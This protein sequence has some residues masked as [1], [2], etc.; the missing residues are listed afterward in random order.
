MRL[1]T[2]WNRYDREIL[3]DLDAKRPKPKESYF[4]AW[5]ASKVKWGKPTLIITGVFVGASILTM[6]WKHI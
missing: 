3:I 4:R 1:V 5:M 6:I 2:L